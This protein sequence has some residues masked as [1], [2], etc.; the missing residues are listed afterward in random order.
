MLVVS[1]TAQAA[2]ADYARPAFAAR[3]REPLAGRY[4]DILGR[5]PQ[6]VQ[7]QIV[8]HMLGRAELWGLKSQRSC[9]AYCEFML[10]I[11]PN[12]DEEPDIRGVLQRGV[13]TR[14]MAIISLPEDAS[15]AAW[16][17]AQLRRSNL[18]LFIPPEL[19]GAPTLDQTV[20]ALP[21][22]LFDRPP[23]PSARAAVEQ[24]LATVQDLGLRALSDAPLVVCV[25]R[26]FWGPDFMKQAWAQVLLRERF[27]P[28]LVLS[29]LRLRLAQDY[30]RYT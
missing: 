17:R 16:S 13:P 7:A 21:V 18:P 2:L 5:F 12:F 29:A 11:A 1:E 8:N 24:A 26:A 15:E 30:G 9:L 10:K 23:Q 19:V 3:L 14:D 6:H 25:C 4:A 28:E 22:V 20:A 27:P